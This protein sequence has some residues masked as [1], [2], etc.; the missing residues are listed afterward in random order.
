MDGSS[1]SSLRHNIPKIGRILVFV[2]ALTLILIVA[3]AS[4]PASLI[5]QSRMRR[6]ERRFAA[7]M[8]SAGRL[9]SWV[10]ARSEVDNGHGTFIGESVV[11]RGYRLWWTPEDIPVISPYP[12]YFEGF[13]L[14]DREHALFFEWCWTRFTSP[15]SGIARLVDI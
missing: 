5:E 7:D 6:R 2:L 11:P 4:I 12:C 3:V 8:K 15:D 9:I 10:D 13:K 14:P 1:R